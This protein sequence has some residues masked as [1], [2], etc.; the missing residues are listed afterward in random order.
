M[1]DNLEA[2]AAEKSLEH[3][4]KGLLSARA[5]ESERA[6]VLLSQQPTVLGR[7]ADPAEKLAALLATESQGVTDEEEGRS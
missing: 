5:E 2:E 4:K 6:Q 7:E 3:F 1:S